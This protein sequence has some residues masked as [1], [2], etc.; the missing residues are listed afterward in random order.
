VE[1]FA[2]R[3]EPVDISLGGLRI[4]SD[5]EYRVSELLRLDIFFPR[6]LLV[7]FT[8]EVMWTKILGKGAPARFDLG[9]AFVELGP[10]ALN[11]LLRALGSETEVDSCPELEVEPALEVVH[12]AIEFASN[13]PSSEVLP[14]TSGPAT[15]RQGRGARSLLCSIPVVA[16]DKLHAAQL[17]A[18]AASLVSLVDGLTTV[19][20]L[21][22]LSAMSLDETLS[23]LKDLRQRG[24]IELR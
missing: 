8:A 1:F 7:T 16:A 3:L 13:E 21:L 4:Y 10:E 17:D 12:S 15:V 5:Q 20:G 6:D 11:V 14:V 23:L 22:E 2:Q 24:I 18:R 9:L 19:E